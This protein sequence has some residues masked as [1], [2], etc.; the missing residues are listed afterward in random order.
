MCCV[1][2][3]IFGLCYQQ[4]VSAQSEAIS[5]NVHVSLVSEVQ[6]IQPGTPF[7]VGLHMRM[8]PGWHTYYRNPGDSGLGTVID[9]NLPQGFE[10]GPITWPAPLRI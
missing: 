2:A 7:W 8:A 3:G 10:A 1:S 6:S 4:E 5:Q 9:W